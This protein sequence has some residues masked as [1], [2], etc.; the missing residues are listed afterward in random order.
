MLHEW[1]PVYVS[2]N[3]VEIPHRPSIDKSENHELKGPQWY[4]EGYPHI[5]KQ[6]SNWVAGGTSVEWALAENAMQSST[7]AVRELGQL[8]EATDENGLNRVEMYTNWLKL[9]MAAQTS[10][11]KH[12]DMYSRK[13]DGSFVENALFNQL[14]GYNGEV[15]VGGIP[16]PMVLHFLQGLEIFIPQLPSLG[17]CPIDPSARNDIQYFNRQAIA[18]ANELRA[19]GVMSSI[20]FAL[21]PTSRI[22]NEDSSPNHRANSSSPISQSV[23]AYFQGAQDVLAFPFAVQRV[24]L[25]IDIAPS[26]GGRTIDPL[27]QGLRM[28]RLM[29]H[30]GANSQPGTAPV[31][32]IDSSRKGGLHLKVSTVGEPPVRNL[33]AFSALYREPL[34]TS[35]NSNGQGGVDFELALAA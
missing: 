32:Y 21:R 10:I 4:V 9:L 14:V 26:V 2:A 12:C 24:G 17:D 16:I 18:L 6:I 7:A 33:S 22:Q 28:L 1:S 19:A 13:P 25:G 27:R 34:F 29:Y 3:S 20:P 11:E 5:L 35:W 15:T 23:A 8:H 31:A 30:V